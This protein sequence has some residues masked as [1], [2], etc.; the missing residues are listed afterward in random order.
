MPTL[1]IFG[2]VQLSEAKWEIL[3]LLSVV[4][5]YLR[6][7]SLLSELNQGGY[8]GEIMSAEHKVYVSTAL[9]NPLSLLLRNTPAYPNHHSRSCGF[10]LTH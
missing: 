10:E 1:S 6:R 4:D 8:Q 7:R 2:G 3:P 9:E 5:C